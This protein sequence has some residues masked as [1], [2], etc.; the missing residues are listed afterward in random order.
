M[1]QTPVYTQALTEPIF[2]TIA[3]AAQNL[4]LNA[5]VI[6]GYVRD[7]LLERKTN[8][9]KDI[10]VVEVG[11]GIALAKEVSNLLP[12]NPKVTVFKNFGTAM[13]KS[14]GW[15]LEFVGARKE[16]YKEDSRK[17]AVEEGTLT[18]DQN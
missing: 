3:K 5:Y 8:N 11:S 1:Q 12:G 18:D 4:E 13:I 6:G 10:D 9:D 15:E 14:T 7:F 2:K 17:P 16:A